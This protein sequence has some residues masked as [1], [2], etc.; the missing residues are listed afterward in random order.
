[1]PIE[2]AS[3]P[4]RAPAEPD[5][6]LPEPSPASRRPAVPSAAVN[7]WRGPGAIAIALAHLGIATDALSARYLFPVALLVDLFFVLSGLV[8]AQAYATKLSKAANI[9]EYVIRRFGRIWPVQAATLAL[10]VGYEAL[11]WAIEASGHGHF[12]SPGFSRDGISLVEA[13]PTNLLLL[14]SLGLHDRETWNFPSWS[15]SVEFVTY[16]AFALFC[17]M[18]P[19]LRRAMSVATI[20][21]SIAILA[22]VAPYGMRST[23]DYGIFRCLAGF[24][25]GTLC[26]EL[27]ER[28]PIP[29]VRYPTLFEVAAV[30]LVG[31]WLSFAVATWAGYAAPIVFALFVLAFL[32]K[33]GQLSRLLRTRVMQV[34]ADL[35]FSI[36][37]VHALVLTALLATAHVFGKAEGV[38]LF[39]AVPN[40][41]DS[42]SGAH[43][44]I[45]VLHID[46]VGSAV[47][48][49]FLYLAGIAA[50]TY[51][52]YR[53]VEVPGRGMFNRLAKR[54]SKLASWG[55]QQATAMRSLE[56]AP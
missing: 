8:I 13:I 24:F 18:T 51:A 38:S 28:W 39:K 26:Y 1:M 41:F 20:V 55:R 40:P 49:L 42:R 36:Y 25:A 10:L 50:A 3:S 19:N 4:D 5:I 44:T 21:A 27:A 52:A 45:E 37:M 15:L 43:S 29:R 23:F 35:S 22:L 32:G 6:R 11:K 53:L 56:R 48:V 31:V 17:L 47:L 16:V 12:S 46:G 14:Q 7:G 34:L 54:L 9:P 2:P 30:A 33:G